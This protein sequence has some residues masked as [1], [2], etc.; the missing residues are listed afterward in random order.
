M[1]S[2]QLA[3]AVAASER[4]VAQCAATSA[5][6]GS[7]AAGTAIAQRLEDEGMG[8]RGATAEALRPAS[9]AARAMSCVRGERPCAPSDGV[10]FNHMRKAAGTTVNEWFAR[11]GRARGFKVH[12]REFTY[13][14]AT[15]S[16]TQCNTDEFFVTA[17]RE[18]I[19]RHISEYYYRGPAKNYNTRWHNPRYCHTL[20]EGA[21]ASACLAELA[22]MVSEPTWMR[23]LTNDSVR[24]NNKAHGGAEAAFKPG[25]YVANT[26]IEYLAARD[27]AYRRSR[28]GGGCDDH[29]CAAVTAPPPLRR[30]IEVMT[31]HD[32]VIIVEWLDEPGY[33]MWLNS[34]L[35]LDGN[36][37]LMPGAE[38]VN[39]HAP[40]SV[41]ATER[42]ARPDPPAAALALMRKEN[43]ADT[44]LYTCAMSEAARRV[45]RWLRD[46][47]IAGP[48]IGKFDFLKRWS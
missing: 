41:D 13:F 23:W 38:N 35:R 42:P 45:H 26:Y 17:L 12:Q 37:S 48:A 46:L 47:D 33:L 36:T 43:A 21:N 44:R 29:P 24:I 31:A 22:D 19:S 8:V 32:L 5:A 30:A 20:T 11:I 9:A 40:S 16:F 15:A 1:L 6:N 2:I 25:A 7:A 18:P 4:G 34:L 14:D 3:A 27:C 39:H 10:F 28:N